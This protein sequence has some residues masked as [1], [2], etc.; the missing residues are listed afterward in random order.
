MRMRAGLCAFLLA[1]LAGCETIPQV[2][3]IELDDRTIEVKPKPEPP[4]DSPS[5]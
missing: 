5:R 4:S 1:I 2:I 3:K